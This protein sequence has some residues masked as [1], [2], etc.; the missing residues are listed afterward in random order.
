MSAVVF[1]DLL[2]IEEIEE[3]GRRWQVAKMLAK[4]YLIQK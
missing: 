2:T 4:K 3:F 1:R